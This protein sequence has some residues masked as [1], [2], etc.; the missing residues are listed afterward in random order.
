MYFG[1]I[2]YEDGRIEIIVYTETPT[3]GD[4][5]PDDMA[6]YVGSSCGCGHHPFGHYEKAAR[7][8]PDGHW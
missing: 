5:D 1:L 7:H 3:E 4:G 8:S 6:A 2:E